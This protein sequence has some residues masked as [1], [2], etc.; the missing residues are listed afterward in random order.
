MFKQANLSSFFTKFMAKKLLFFT[1]QK[2]CYL[3]SLAAR[4][5]FY[6]DRTFVLPIFNEALIEAE[7][8]IA[9]I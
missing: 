4:P 5:D 2:Y 6:R 7:L 3:T 8:S 9:S 1:R